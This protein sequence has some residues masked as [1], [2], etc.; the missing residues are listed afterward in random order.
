MR[1]NHVLANAH[2]ECHTDHQRSWAVEA[3]RL[4]ETL[5]QAGV[6]AE[7]ARALLANFEDEPPRGAFGPAEFRRL[8]GALDAIDRIAALVASA[9]GE[10]DDEDDE[11]AE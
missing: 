4:E 8:K 3:T 9:T 7:V 5:Y 10:T 2:P 1:A 6:D 11:A